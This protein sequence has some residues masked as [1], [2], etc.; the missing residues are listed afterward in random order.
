MAIPKMQPELEDKITGLLSKMGSMVNEGTHP[1]DALHKV[2]T[3]ERVPAG[4]VRLMANAYNTGRTLH[5]MREGGGLHEKLAEFPLADAADVL[6][7]MFPAEVKTAA[8][9]YHAAAISDDYALPPHWH[10]NRAKAEEKQAAASQIDLI[11]GWRELDGR[12]AAPA[13]YPQDRWHSTKQAF[14]DKSRLEQ[15]AD[16]LRLASIGANYTA[17]GTFD[18]L[19]AYFRQADALPFGAVY[20]NAVLIHGDRAAKV[21]DK[22][23]EQLGPQSRRFGN[24]DLREG[25]AT[26]DKQAQ[27]VETPALERPGSIFDNEPP[28]QPPPLPQRQVIK[29]GSHPHLVDWNRAP[30]SLITECFTAC[31]QSVAAKQ[32]YETFAKEAGEKIAEYL[33]PFVPSGNGVITGSVWD[34]VSRTKEAG[35][36]L[37]FAAGSALGNLAKGMGDKLVPPRQQLVDKTVERLGENDN[38]LRA[39]QTQTM[40]HDLMNN[41]P[42]LAGYQPEQV[43]DA[44]NQLSEVAPRAAQHRMIT[45]SLLRKY[46]EQAT[47]VDAFDVDQLLGVEKKLIEQDP[48]QRQKSPVQSQ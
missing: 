11:A 33:R 46:L 18:K 25:W 35:S 2:A 8:A 45:Q 5:Q 28:P 10:V 47:A 37:P 21:L 44:Y 20:E 7:R 34:A 39:I 3:A 27:A 22:V 12:E 9:Q 38:R 36:I 40:L 14:D 1:T 26:V 29:T 32:E 15:Q 13:A 17:L 23:A 19:A 43:V 31:E 6:E 30:Y 41:D 16:D 24:V 48:S 42:I 4:H